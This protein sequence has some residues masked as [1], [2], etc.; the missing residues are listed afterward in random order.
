MKHT[1]IYVPGLGD[2]YQWIRQACLVL[3]RILGGRAVLFDARWSSDEA[4]KDKRRRLAAQIAQYERTVLVG[5]SAG[6]T[7]CLNQFATDAQK[8]SG[9]VTLCGVCRPDLPIGPQY[10]RNLPVFV[11]SVR[12][13]SAIDTSSTERVICMR[14]FRDHVVPLPYSTVA[15]AKT[16]ALWSIGHLPTIFLALT[17][18]APIVWRQISRLLK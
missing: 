8:V 13:L 15:G 1:I 11:Q 10:Q 7:L 16:T 18:Y 2:G 12:E 3:W 9:V 4:L 6:A 17:L 5:E 14:A